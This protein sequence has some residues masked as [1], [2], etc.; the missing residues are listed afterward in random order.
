MREKATKESDTG[1]ASVISKPGGVWRFRAIE[2]NYFFL[3][4]FLEERVDFL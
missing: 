3:N 4:R 2:T 1:A